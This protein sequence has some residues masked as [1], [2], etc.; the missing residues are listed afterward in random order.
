MLGLISPR[1][2]RAQ[3]PIGISGDITACVGDNKVYTPGISDAAYT[4]LWSVAPPGTGTVL[5]GNHTGA[6]I[7]WM[8]PGTST[9]WLY[10]TDPLNG[11]DTVYSGNLNVTIS[12]MPA[13]FITSNVELGCQ[14]LNEDSSRGEQPPPPKFDSTH[15]QLV[16]ENSMV[17][18]TA[19]GDAGSTFTWVVIGALSYSPS[20]GPYCDVNWGAPGFGEV[21][22]TETSA[23]GCVTETSFC[24]EIIQ[25]PNAKFETVPSGLPDPIVICRYG[26]LVLQD[27][28]T[29]SASSP[30]VSYL[31]DWG[32]GHT[33]PMSPG[34][35]SSPV[36]HVY[37]DPGDYIVTLTV[38]NS[39]G[40]VST[41]ER[42]VH[43]QE[44]EAPKIACPRVVCEGERAVYSIPPEYRCA[45]DSWTVEGGTIIYADPERVEVVWDNVD[46]NT[47]FGYVM[48]KTC[49]P[50]RMTVVEPVPV[51][52]KNAIIQGPQIICQDK[53]YVF[54]LPKWPSTEFNWSVSGP[55][56]IQPTDQ[57]NEIAVTASGPGSIT[58]FCNY[59]N[60]VLKCGGETGFDIQVLPP[61][62]ISGPEAVCEGAPAIFSLS[63]PDPGNWT[64]YTALGAFVASGT[65]TS[66]PYTFITPGDYRLTVTGSTFCPPEDHMIS[67]VA[68]P[69][70][71]D[72]ITGPDRSC[73]GIPVRYDAGNPLAGTT[74]HW[75][76]TGGGSASA[77]VGDY[78]YI[79]FGTLPAYVN[80]VR[81]TTD[82]LG[83]ASDAISYYV[84]VAVP[85]LSIAGPDTVC[86]S[87]IESY[88]LNYGEGDYY[89][90]EIVDPVIGSVVANGST[91][92]PDIQWNM[93]VSP[94]SGQNVWLIAKVTKCGIVHRDTLTVF[95]RGTPDITG[96][97]ISP[98][99]TV[100]SDVPVTLTVNTSYPLSSG[101]FIVNWGDGI[102]TY[103]YPAPI[104]HTYSTTGTTAPVIYTPTVT[105]VD[106]NGC[107]GSVTANAPQITVMPVPV[108]ILSPTGPIGHCG[109]GWADTLI[110][111]V[112][113]GIGGSNSYTWSTPSTNPGNVNINPYGD[114][115]G[116]YNVTVSNSVFGCSST[117]NTVVIYDN[118]T[119][120][121]P[122]N[123]GP[124]CPPA[125]D[126]TLGFAN[127]CGALTLTPSLSGGTWSTT[128][129]YIS[130]LTTDPFTGEGTATATAAGMYTFSYSRYYNDTCSKTYF[131]T[132]TVPY[133]ADLR[134]EITC[135]QA[136]GKYTVNLFD[137]STDYP[138][139][140]ITSR[141]YYELPSWTLLG[142]GMSA[143]T[144]QNPG[145]TVTYAEV[146]QGGINPACTSYVS[147]TTPG[148]PSVDV[149]IHPT[150]QY[151]P[152]CE[153][154][155]A[156]MLGHTILSGTITSYLWD[157]D[158]VNSF[159]ASDVNPIGKVYGNAG[160]KFPSLRVTDIYGCWA[161]DQVTVDVVDNPY[162]AALNVLGSPACQG[163]AVT[164]V[165]DDLFTGYPGTYIWHKESDPVYTNTVPSYNVFEPG[166]Y[167]ALGRNIYGCEVTTDMKPVII[168][169][170]P[171]VSIMG[172]A[173]ACVN[174]PFTLTT[175]NYG[176]GYFY[177]WYGAA[178]GTG[179]SLTQTIAIPGDY[180]Y[181]VV[182]VDLATGCSDTSAEFT[183]TVSP[184]PPPPYLYFN[185][186]S[187]DPYSVDLIAT[188]VPGTYNW[189]NGMTGATVNTPFGGGY[190]VTL[191]DTNGCVVHN[192]MTV[193]KSLEEYIWVFPTGCFCGNKEAYVIG[194]I[195]PL[196]WA[197]MKDGSFDI[198]GWGYMPPYWPD[199]GHIYNMY[200]NNG[201]CS[202]TSDDMYYLSDT[203]NRLPG[204]AD[205]AFEAEYRP[206]Q[207]DADRNLL[208]VSP[209]PAGDYAMAHFIVAAGSKTR[210][211]ELVDIT[212][213]VLQTHTLEYDKGSIRLALH[214][215]ASG[216]Y[217]VVLRRDGVVVQT[218]KLS[219]TQ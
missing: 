87:T 48:Y 198:S 97:D 190:Q 125:P 86:H 38:V 19:N 30:I 213:R 68:T 218:M 88:F 42:K 103:P 192:T 49:D 100:C 108:A 195:I 164:L 104:T 53:Q 51:V 122:G 188:G 182:I 61:E 16:C 161:Q 11:N 187:C 153:E 7:Q 28:S 109:T 76:V 78:S 194:P 45:P 107:L 154:D 158:D 8:S 35:A 119:P 117:S 128:S 167:W 10:V 41:F 111:T 102:G 24:V 173:G 66:F 5:S 151:L 175:Q 134:Y 148:F 131:I 209:N 116:S 15:C 146:I 168:N 212:G 73:P 178:S 197:W 137:H 99:D 98:N 150:N 75:S 85:P 37:E 199:P 71:P 160:L 82:G 59:I 56:I 135:N 72:L 156:F 202:L 58:L 57:R 55:A 26:E 157:F 92:N 43:V 113:T 155:V 3:A 70:L 126:V 13:P 29:A 139:T 136:L 115:F 36:S 143:G 67:V 142:T 196:N 62:T 89:E 46:P 95:V 112:T 180:T 23:S 105:L 169:Q 40:C 149:F 47:G 141:T 201:W 214:Q 200:L 207:P 52:L 179:T 219:K 216:M 20:S 165:Y 124:G 129:P 54:R 1:D 81:T 176:S 90:W 50:C 205:G 101:T 133:T 132:V 120:G 208:E 21:R 77:P 25:G 185:I 163:D 166:G 6:T 147:V 203:C 60:T 152:G 144:D 171:P 110:A 27:I 33:T 14:P 184:P 123:P 74:F 140:S 9:I 69:E 121:S 127:D 39:C 80:V 114:A 217:N 183:V 63:G 106:A 17:Q 186:L 91:I 34:A 65:G 2:G 12:A 170:V 84:D 4:Y 204:N 145:T 189:S 174:Q 193:P 172:N 138:G 83:C 177:Y 181:N 31:W 22:L 64:L 210:S 162:M 191:T 18:Y 44:R 96:I 215:Y 32:D 159:N 118:C 94:P 206:V 79:T 130:G 93:P 211:I